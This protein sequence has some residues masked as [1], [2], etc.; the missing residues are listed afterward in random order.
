LLG[1]DGGDPP[2]DDGDHGDPD[3]GSEEVWLSI[4]DG[5]EAAAAGQ[6]VALPSDYDELASGL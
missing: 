5:V 3:V 4:E 2:R 6:L 1:P